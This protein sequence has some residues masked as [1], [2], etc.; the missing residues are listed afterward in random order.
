MTVIW[1]CVD[2]RR[3]FPAPTLEDTLAKYGIPDPATGINLLSLGRMTK[4]SAH[5]GYERLLEVFARVASKLPKLRLVFGGR[6][7]MIAS[8]R[9]R[10]AALHLADRVHFL[11]SIDESDLA[12]VYRTAHIFSLVSDRGHGRGEG[13]PLTPLEAAACGVPLLVG[14]H[15]GS[16]EAV[17]EGDNG[18]ICDPFDLSA[19][20]DR[21]TR[22][23]SDT[24]LRG[25]MARRAHQRITEH[26]TFE[27]F[28]SEHAALY[29][30]LQNGVAVA[31]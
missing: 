9:E 22:L 17:V 19:H 31:H 10:A 4:D 12:N 5:K 28:T 8:L 26:F 16:Q 18:F 24:E 7:D 20:A 13:I 27:R 25:R 29:E 3:F 1:D 30:Q 15:D 11:G 6:G 23:V 2:T 21:I 14:N